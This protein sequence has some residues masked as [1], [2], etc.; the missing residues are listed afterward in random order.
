MLFEVNGIHVNIYGI[1]S[2]LQNSVLE[3]YR[4]FDPK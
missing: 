3:S 2:V 4:Q 1:V